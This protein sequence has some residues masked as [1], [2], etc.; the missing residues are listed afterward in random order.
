[1]EQEEKCSKTN[2]RPSI[3]PSIRD[4]ECIMNHEEVIGNQVDGNYRKS[5]KLVLG[6]EKPKENKR[7]GRNRSSLP[8]QTPTQ[9]R[10]PSTPPQDDSRENATGVGKKIHGTD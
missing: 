9:S 1:M 5:T 6:Y 2:H 3:M 8:P 4:R 7:K 10:Q